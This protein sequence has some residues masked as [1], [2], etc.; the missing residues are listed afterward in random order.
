MPVSARGNDAADFDAPD[1]V[2]FSSTIPA[3]GALHQASCARWHRVALPVG[4]SW[5]IDLLNVELPLT[6]NKLR[7]PCGAAGDVC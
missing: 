7:I 6:V 3:A 5:G 4:I 1:E 2:T